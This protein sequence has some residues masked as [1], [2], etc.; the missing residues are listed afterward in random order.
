MNKPLVSIIIPLYN[1]EKY[2]AETIRSAQNQTWTNKEIIVVDDGS[3]DNSLEVANSCKDRHT[4]VITQQNKGASA[5]RNA[6]LNEAKGEYIQFLDADDL[7]SESKIAAQVEVLIDY[8]NQV[9][10]CGTVHFQ[11]GEIPSGSA[12]NHEWYAIGSDNPADFL[13]KLYGGELIGPEYGGMITIHAWLCPKHILDKAG[14][15]NEELSVDDDG[16]YFCRV[17]LACRGIKYT[18]DGVSYYRK[19]N[20]RPSLSAQKTYYAYKGVL[21]STL[22]K[23]GYLT[24]KTSDVRAKAVLSRLLWDNAYNF[25][26]HYKDLAT[27]AEKHARELL[28]GFRFNPFKKG[29][30]FWI[31]S[32]F[33]WKFFKRLQYLKYKIKAGF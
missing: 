33:G 30:N 11:D 2:I 22:L 27:I 23:A 15:W 14:G 31:V 28:P 9:G 20:N 13:I 26:P 17:L 12:I 1:S 29:L 24:A 6:G 8:P 10:L 3:T 5:A 32:V 25:Y 7:L 16:E 4:R 19:F 21:K 18:K